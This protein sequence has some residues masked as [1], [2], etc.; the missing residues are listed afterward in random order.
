M[1][2]MERATKRDDVAQWSQLDD[3]FHS[4]IVAL[5]GNSRLQTTLRQY[6]DQ[7]YRARMAIVPLRPRP[8]QSDEEHRAIVAAI[9]A[10][11]EAEAG[12]LHQMHRDR[13]DQQ[14]LELLRLHAGPIVPDLAEDQT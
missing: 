8:S 13:T 5:C 14:A 7:Q 6:W 12:R 11:D 1:A 9:A 3:H 2:Q 10:R 4:E